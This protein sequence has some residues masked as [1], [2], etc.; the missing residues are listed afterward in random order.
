MALNNADSL[1]K[2]QG[3]LRSLVIR[4]DMTQASGVGCSSGVTG[5]VGYRTSMFTVQ[6]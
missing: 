2:E 4:D 5:R 1:I 6:E 3:L